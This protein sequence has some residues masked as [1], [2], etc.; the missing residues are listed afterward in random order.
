MVKETPYPQKTY[1]LVEKTKTNQIQYSARMQGNNFKEGKVLLTQS[2]GTRHSR[3]VLDRQSI[4]FLL[5]PGDGEDPRSMDAE[6]C[7]QP[8][9]LPLYI[10]TSSLSHPFPRFLSFVRVHSEL[11]LTGI[12]VTFLLTL[13]DLLTT[14]FFRHSCLANPLLFSFSSWSAEQSYRKL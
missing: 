11:H 2:T 14:L 1:R 13:L 10:V 12:P 9:S 5:Q 8:L 3:P 4:S 7:L 6:I